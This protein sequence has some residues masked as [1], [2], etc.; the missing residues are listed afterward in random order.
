MATKN[1]ILHRIRRADYG[2]FDCRRFLVEL[3]V[4]IY[5]HEGLDAI[6]PRIMH[7]LHTRTAFC[8]PAIILQADDIWQQL[9]D[10]PI[11]LG[12]VIKS[13]TGTTAWYSVRRELLRQCVL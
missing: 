4:Y 3:G 10:Q 9:K 13:L 6:D 7:C 1:Q 8:L 12:N 5:D 2:W 11:Y